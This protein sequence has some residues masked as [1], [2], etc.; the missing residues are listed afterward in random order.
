MPGKVSSVAVRVRQQ[1]KEGDRLLSIEAMKM[2]TAVY[3]PRD[4]TV[5][6]AHVEAGTVVEAKD[7]LLV[8]QD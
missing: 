1:V 2:E 5:A 7:L 8:L 4:A 6:A 3:S